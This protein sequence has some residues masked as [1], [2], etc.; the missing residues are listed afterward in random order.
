MKLSCLLYFALSASLLAQNATLRGVV[1]DGSGAAVA[2]AKITIAG[3]NR[4]SR[5][6]A[7]DRQG[8]YTFT[9]LAPGAY[10]L[11]ASAPRLFLPEVEINLAAGMNT[12]D[13]RLSIAPVVESINVEESPP[14]IGTDASANASATILRG[15]DLEA[16]SDTPEDLLS[17]LQALAGPSAGPNGGSIYV[18]G[19]SG[20]ELP[21]KE[22]IREIRINQN[23]FSPE[24]DKLGLGRIEIL[25]KPGADQWHGNLNYNFATDAW[26]SR[27]PYSAIK[28]PLRLN[29]YENAVS[30]RIS[31]RA[32]LSL[33]VNQN[34]V[35]NGAIVNAVTL[36]PNTLL[37]T[38][39]FDF[40]KTI[41]R[42]TNL[43]PRID[44]QL[45]DNNTLTLRYAFTHGTIQGAGING[46]N[47]TSRGENRDYTVQTVQVIETAVLSP[48]AINET[49]FQF[50]R[51]AFESTPNS[52]LPAIQ[53][54]GA[55][56]GGGTPGGASR[57][58]EQDLEFQ[59][60]TT[61]ARGPHTG[62]DWAN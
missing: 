29:E 50:Y 37:P 23:P 35:D 6:E 1:T 47:L 7:S 38:P 58:V 39:F 28:A 61:I 48:G 22:S 3:K 43:Y 4:V 20:G 44:Y 9:S 18:D 27:N 54:L 52:L 41:Q 5:T 12:T 24:F 16:L 40:F 31:K 59:N 42:R 45:N 21:P 14:A 32:S 25:T 36:D 2:S 10:T 11:Q 19:F 30:G 60:N 8:V 51:N 49:R 17:D 15:A 53:V 33:D 13:I 46:F 56:N 34:N 26:N 55:F 57:N 62:P